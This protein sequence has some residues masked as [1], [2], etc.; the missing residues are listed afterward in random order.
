MI[1]P[2]PPDAPGGFIVCVGTGVGVS[3]VGIGVVE[4]EEGTGELGGVAGT[5]AAPPHPFN[6]NKD[7]LKNKDSIIINNIFLVLRILSPLILTVTINFL[8]NS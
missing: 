2:S 1:G 4:G 3:G 5:L 8:K 7:K 6:N